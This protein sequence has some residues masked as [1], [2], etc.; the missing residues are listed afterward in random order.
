MI[1]LTQFIGDTKFENKEK[2]IWFSRQ[3]NY[4][5]LKGG[6]SLASEYSQQHPVTDKNGV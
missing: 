5:I 3:N 4:I 6:K 1:N 2:S